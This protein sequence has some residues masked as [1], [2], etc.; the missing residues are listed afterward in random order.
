MSSSFRMNALCMKM[1]GYFFSHSY[2]LRIERILAKTSCQQTELPAG[3]TRTPAGE[4][5]PE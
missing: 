2:I 5:I 4:K 1:I 3:N